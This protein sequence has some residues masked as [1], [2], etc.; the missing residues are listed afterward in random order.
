M[1]LEYFVVLHNLLNHD[2]LF[3]VASKANLPANKN[4]CR[5]KLLT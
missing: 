5:K 1:G 4:G 2:K 3:L